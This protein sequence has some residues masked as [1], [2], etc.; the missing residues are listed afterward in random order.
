MVEEREENTVEN[1]LE[2]KEMVRSNSMDNPER[3][4]NTETD[5]DKDKRRTKIRIRSTNLLRDK[6][7]SSKPLS[8]LL[9]LNMKKEKLSVMDNHMKTTLPPLR[10]P[11]MSKEKKAQKPRATTRVRMNIPEPRTT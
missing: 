3:L 11:L 9:E 8:Q 1:G 6:N 5:G 2:R 7:H 4:S 10:A